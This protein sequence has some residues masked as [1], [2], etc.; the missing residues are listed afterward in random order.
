MKHLL[1]LCVAS[2]LTFNAEAAADEVEALCTSIFTPNSLGW[3]DCI[4]MYADGL[5]EEHPEEAL[6]F[7]VMEK[8]YYPCFDATQDRTN[9]LWMALAAVGKEVEFSNR[10]SNEVWPKLNETVDALVED[11][12]G[13]DEAARNR[14][15]AKFVKAC[16]VAADRMLE[17]ALRP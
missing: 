2:L 6:R 3:N 11:L 8:F 10:L 16:A 15:Y 9:A 17:A 4:A 12:L 1:T 13:Q 5:P 14:V 7:E